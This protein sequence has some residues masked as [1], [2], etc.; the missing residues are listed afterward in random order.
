MNIYKDNN[1]V[2][3]ENIYYDGR[4][5]VSLLAPMNTL[6]L[7]SLNETILIK[8]SKNG[9]VLCAVDEENLY[10]DGTLVDPE[11][12]SVDFDAIAYSEGSGPG[13]GP[14]PTE[15]YFTITNLTDEDATLKMKG[16]A[17]IQDGV[18]GSRWD[19]GPTDFTADMSFDNGETWS[20]ITIT[21]ASSLLIPG[22]G[23]V[24]MKNGNY[25]NGRVGQY[26]R[27]AGFECSKNYKVSG[28]ILS[29]MRPTM[30]GS[31]A[32]CSGMFAAEETLIDAGD[33]IIDYLNENVDYQYSCLFGGCK[34]LIKAPALPCTYVV[35][36]CYCQMFL[37]CENLVTA[38]QLPATVIRR[39]NASHINMYS[40]M[41]GCCYRLV[42]PPARIW[43]DAL[44]NWAALEAMF[45][46]CDS[47]KVMPQFN[48]DATFGSY[49][50]SSVFA[51]S[52][53]ETVT[54]DIFKNGLAQKAQMFA[55]CSLLKT[56]NGD[57]SNNTW[58][59]LAN[60][61]SNSP[62]YQT[63]GVE[64]VNLTGALNYSLNISNW[65]SL[66]YASVK[67]ILTA[68]ASTDNSNSKTLTFNCSVTDQSSE[69]ANLVAECVTK[70]W[71]I[72]G[73]TIL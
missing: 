11:T 60:N 29:I 16:S 46:H 56:F 41:F 64:N 36:G 39:V 37:H 8:S 33:L 62:F 69:I 68:A 4:N 34:N 31:D 17:Y 26:M 40:W 61:S 2:V 49:T 72:S 67:N 14:T 42:N 21:D 13:P 63:Y 38:P 52:G 66:T 48:V 59:N 70:G 19:Y 51:Y 32:V 73:L 1:H 53:L 71:T 5:D 55:N 30:G 6:A 3:I 24:M 15:E 23:K 28:K 7:D 50:Y 20:T 58:D 65:S 22:N 57:L 18:A 10:L 54:T 44:G 35:P 47:L 25:Y 9:D 27:G 43:F 12:L 45:Y